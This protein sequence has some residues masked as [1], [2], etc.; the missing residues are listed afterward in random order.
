MNNFISYD[1]ICHA[2]YKTDQ[3]TLCHLKKQKQNKTK[4][5]K[6]KTKLAWLLYEHV[7]GTL[8]VYQHHAASVPGVCDKRD[9]Y[10]FKEMWPCLVCTQ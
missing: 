7:F 4:K 1:I 9:H 6:P 8:N 5:K 2:A 10:K 3:K